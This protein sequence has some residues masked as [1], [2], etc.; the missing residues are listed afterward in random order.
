MTFI[1][2]RV[3]TTAGKKRISSDKATENKRN[4]KRKFDSDK[5]VTGQASV[6]RVSAS[7]ERG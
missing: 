4:F 6:S 1:K 7:A 3:K 2:M 5:D